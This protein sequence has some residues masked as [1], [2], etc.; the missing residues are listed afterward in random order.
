[1][2][3]SNWSKEWAQHRACRR[4]SGGACIYSRQVVGTRPLEGVEC[5]LPPVPRVVT[6]H[7]FPPSQGGSRR[8]SQD[9]NGL[10]NITAS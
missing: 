1:M 2:L 8:R 9:T 5:A 6:R 7:F 10:E 3:S 4:R